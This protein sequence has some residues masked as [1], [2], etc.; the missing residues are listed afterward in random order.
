LVSRI[1][2]AGVAL[3]AAWTLS[4]FVAAPPAVSASLPRPRVLSLD[5]CADQY[6]LAL[7]ARAAVVG[8]S[9]RVGNADSWLAARA[10]GLPILRADAEAALAAR[11]VV[12]VRYWGGDPKLL[13]ILARRGARIITL[14]DATGFAGVRR[15]VRT[16]AAALGAS[17]EGEGLIAGMD[18]QLARSA[19]AWRGKGA[20]YLTSGGATTGPG[21]LID[22]MLRA[23]GLRNLTREPGFHELSLERLTLDPPE[24][25]VEGFFDSASEARVHWGLGRHGA[26][27]RLTQGRTLVS[28]PGA[29]L[30]CPAWFVGDAVSLIARA[31]PRPRCASSDDGRGGCA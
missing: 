27:N 8:L 15:N 6:V 18:R 26:L 23:A 16:V 25:V 19:G 12:V 20:V 7:G 30:G 29:L 22:T 1:A 28:L 4:L 17:A 24:A 10:V 11:P 31:A 13:A 3:G 9:P 14:E 2:I 21:S 5:Q